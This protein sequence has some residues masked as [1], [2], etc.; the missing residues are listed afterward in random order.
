MVS[1]FHSVFAAPYFAILASGLHVPQHF[2]GASF[3]HVPQHFFVVEQPTPTNNATIP[4]TANVNTFFILLS[5]F[6]R[7]DPSDRTVHRPQLAK[8]FK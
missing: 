1:H 5:P 7:P 2:T 8:R 3:L 4:I 6:L